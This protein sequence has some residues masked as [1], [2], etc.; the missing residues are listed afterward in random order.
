MPYHIASSECTATCFGSHK[1]SSSDELLPS[2]FTVI[3]LVKM[4]RASQHGR[5][6]WRKKPESL[7]GNVSRCRLDSGCSYLVVALW[8]PLSHLSGR[9]YQR[10]FSRLHT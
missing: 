5:F 9:R 1:A 8:L 10:P 7:L 3:D 2:F 6:C 4:T